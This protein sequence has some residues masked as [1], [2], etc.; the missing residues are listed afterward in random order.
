MGRQ[1]EH[2]KL[3]QMVK[4][5]FQDSNKVVVNL[6]NGIF[7]ENFKEDEIDIS[8]GNNEFIKHSLDIIRADM[9][10]KVQKKDNLNKLIKFHIEF[11]MKNDITMA[12]RAFEYG[13]NIANEDSDK[14]D[15]ITTL[16]FPKQKIIF[17]E[18]NTGVDDILKL[19]LVFPN[20]SEYNYSVEVIKYWEYST[21]MIIA[22][23]LYPLI[24]FQLFTLRKD[25]EKSSSRKKDKVNTKDIKVIELAKS[26][27][28]ISVDLVNDNEIDI[29]YFNK[30]IVVISNMINYF[31]NEYFMD[32]NIEEEFRM[33]VK[34]LYDPIVEKR[35][36]ERGEKRGEKIGEKKA[37][38]K[39][40]IN[41][42]DILDDETIALKTGLKIEEVKKLR[43][44]NLN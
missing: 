23:K 40:A 7:N 41:L 38:I 21:E 43:K 34:S 18:K 15:G 13:F 25:L 29:D 36:E 4:Y 30:M 37:L 39:V 28:D 27:S 33:Y 9:V 24:P 26:L 11:Q 16:Y 5:L 42:L 8:I 12:I 17:F 44:E 14:K 35:G 10:Y 32:K 3:D 1:K 20:G 31:N 2:I 6:L 22:K 19:K